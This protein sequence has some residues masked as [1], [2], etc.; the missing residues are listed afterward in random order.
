MTGPVFLDVNVAMYAGGADH[1][2]R[3]PCRRVIR[4]VAAGELEA[5]TDAEVFQEILYRYAYLGEP[6]L[7][8]RIFDS[9]FRLMAGRILPVDEGVMWDTRRLAEKHPALSPRDVIHVAVMLWNEV[10]EIVSV[11]PDF[12]RVPA[13]RRLDPRGFSV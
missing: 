9:L 4:A 5:V 7:G 10:E 11:D 12:D 8:F 2:L 3:E 6:E 1:P 13:V